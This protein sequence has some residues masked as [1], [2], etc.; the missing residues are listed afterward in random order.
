MN[1][2]TEIVW[3]SSATLTQTNM[4]GRG[5]RQRIKDDKFNRNNE[6][7]STKENN[8]F[9]F[10][11]IKNTDTCHLASV[12]DEQFETM[13]EYATALQKWMVQYSAWCMFQSMAYSPMANTVNME[14]KIAS[15][16]LSHHNQINSEPR[17]NV[18]ERGA[19][20]IRYLRLF[21]FIL[22]LVEV[23]LILIEI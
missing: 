20:S 12:K 6:S 10:D 11:N 8:L 23:F 7:H 3:V 5:V 19:I 16:S 17:R 9:N 21:L 14:Q 2:K 1:F 4:E 18:E 22:M 15:Q 13:T